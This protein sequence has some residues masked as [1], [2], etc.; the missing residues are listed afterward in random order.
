MQER[1]QWIGHDIE[2]K[3]WKLDCGSPVIAPSKIC[4]ARHF[5]GSRPDFCNQKSALQEVVEDAG[6]IFELY[7]KY[8]CECNWIEMYWG[9]AKREAR[10]KCDYT[11]KSLEQNI[12]SFLDKAGG[13]A[14]IRRYFRRATEYIEAYS[15]CSDGREVVQAVKKFAEKK[16]LSHRKIR[17]PADLDRE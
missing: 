1:R 9:G 4:C 15:K 8:H 17:I 5:L 11:F 6:H 2:G 12:D 7:P 14:R 10:L 16:Y 13:I 3:A